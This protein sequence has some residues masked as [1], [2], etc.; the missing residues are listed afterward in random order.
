MISEE[1]DFMFCVECGNIF[2][3]EEAIPEHYGTAGWN[4]EDNI[5]MTCPFCSSDNIKEAF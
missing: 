5:I 2:V 4:G 1:L 3:R